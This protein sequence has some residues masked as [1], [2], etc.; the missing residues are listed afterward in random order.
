LKKNIDE[1]I[2]YSIVE[3]DGIQENNII[4]FPKNE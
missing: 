3:R 4:D 1:E 2:N